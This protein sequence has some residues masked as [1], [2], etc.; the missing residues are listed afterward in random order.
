MYPLVKGGFWKNTEDEILKVGVMKYGKNQWAR[1]S[2]LLVRKT[3][4]QCKA[5]WHEWIDPSVKKIEWSREEEEKL[6]HLA[7][8]M[9]MQWKTIASIVGRTA[10]Q[11][12]EHYE[13]MLNEV[14][15]REN[16]GIDSYDEIHRLRAGEV[17]SA[18]ETKP[19]KPDPV[20]MDEDEKEMLSEARARLANT[21]GKKAKRKAR[22]KQLEEARRLASLQKRKELK[23]V[24]IKTR[25]KSSK[26]LDYNVDIPFQR[27]APEGPFDTTDELERERKDN[28]VV[29]EMQN[30]KE[31]NEKMEKAKVSTEEIGKL[32]KIVE[33]Q[34]GFRRTKLI[35]PEPQLGNE[36][37]EQFIKLGM[38]NEDAR[39]LMME[40]STPSTPFVNEN[41]AS[42]PNVS[43]YS[44][45]TMSTPGSV[46]TVSNTPSR[47]IQ[48]SG[49]ERKKRKIQN[50][51]LE[52]GFSQLPIP[53]NDFE[54]VFPPEDEEI[55]DEDIK[56]IVRNPSNVEKG[57]LM[58][59]RIKEHG[60]E[61]DVV[62]REMDCML[63]LW[64]E[65]KDVYEDIRNAD[66][67]QVREMVE[68]ISRS[69]TRRDVQ[70]TEKIS[71]LV[72]EEENVTILRK[73]FELM[74]ARV[75]DDLARAK[76]MEATME[77]RL[78]I[79]IRKCQGLVNH[80]MDAGTDWIKKC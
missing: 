75:V 12:L 17:D 79:L 36:E 62:K 41:Y 27:K 18:P 65:E 38:T 5:R 70:K 20:D 55:D 52:W 42:T 35:L 59:Q 74:Q 13:R 8:I 1:I 4:K 58:P 19:A 78:E 43:R 30:K 22:E 7:K 23:E 50:V 60:D 63:R 54:I 68:N 47:E 72:E 32:K 33:E 57:L 71:I 21:Q 26:G 9:P 48:G 25:G 64:N 66:L 29:L 67:D 45:V 15:T 14:V 44:L 77:R 40:D 2:S 3:A 69:M 56:Y 46:L 6:L 16:G 80:N 28:S 24:G 39:L 10:S 76:S 31:G 49:E 11:C 51:E 53:K 37:L 61:I 73:T 34:F